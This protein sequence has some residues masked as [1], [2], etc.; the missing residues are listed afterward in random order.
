MRTINYLEEVNPIP[1]SPPEE[2]N[3]SGLK[4]EMKQ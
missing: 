3:H 1:T 4:Y 2:K